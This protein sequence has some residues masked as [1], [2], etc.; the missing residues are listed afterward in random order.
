M[1]T[2][3]DYGVG[4]L[5]SIQNMLK[6][7]G[8][9]AVI[10]STE[11]GLMD[12]S[13]LILPGVGAFDTCAEKLKQSGLLNV[14]N[15]KVLSEKTPVLGICVGMQLLLE[16][17]EEGQQLG[18][19]WIR[20]KNIRFKQSQLPLGFKVPHM[21]WTDVTLAKESK[22]FQNMS[23]EPRFYFVHSYHPQL[24]NIA[25]ALIN[26]EYGYRFVAGIEHENI[27]GVQ[28]HPEKSHTFGM[29]F[30]ENFATYF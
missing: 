11:N 8:V 9:E 2:I 12:A 26:A 30:L 25:D 21:G 5:A 22:L 6:R 10:S 13:K 28:F 18:L 15:K 4:N 23:D 29:R 3:V 27:V 1:V 16:G 19:G 7:I 20:G 14:L 17:S 24:I